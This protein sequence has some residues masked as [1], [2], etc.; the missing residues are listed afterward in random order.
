[1]F[2]INNEIIKLTKDVILTKTNSYDN[3]MDIDDI[4]S[5]LILWIAN[6]NSNINNEFKNN[7]FKQ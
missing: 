2:S 1:M 5:N 4:N 7:N 6:F 3:I